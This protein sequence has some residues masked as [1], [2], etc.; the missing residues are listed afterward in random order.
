M[1]RYELVSGNSSKFWQIDLDDAAFTTS[2]G[3][4]GTSGQTKTKTFANASAA[5][6]AHDK[7]VAEK[8]KKGYVLVVDTTSAPAPSAPHEPPAAAPAAAPAPAE[9][10]PARAVE[11]ADE[12]LARAVEPADEALA[13]AVEP[14]LALDPA[15]RS[16][17]DPAAYPYGRL[18]WTPAL[19]KLAAESVAAVAPITP[20][21]GEPAVLYAQ[22]NRWTR[23]AAKA[24]IENG[25]HYHPQQPAFV[26]QV[27]WAYFAAAPP[28]SLDVEVESAAFLMLTSVPGT[29]QRDIAWTMI[30]Y[31]VAKAGLAFAVEAWART[32]S[33]WT[34]MGYSWKTQ[35]KLV[36]LPADA[37]PLPGA[38]GAAPPTSE[39]INRHDVVPLLRRLLADADDPAG[40]R[41]HVDTLLGGADHVTRL[42]LAVL[43]VDVASIC[44]ALTARGAL[45]REMF[46]IGWDALSLVDPEVLPELFASMGRTACVHLGSVAGS[47]YRRETDLGPLVRLFDRHREAALPA[48]FAWARR[49]VDLI[50]EVGGPYHDAEVLDLLKGLLGLFANVSDSRPL[51]EMLAE[52]Q[53]RFAKLK[54]NKDEDPR[55]AALQL[56]NAM[57][58]LALGAV[59]AHRQQGWAKRVLPQLERATGAVA[60][61]PVASDDRIPSELRGQPFTGAPSFWD[62]ELLPQLLLDEHSALPPASVNTIGLALSRDDTV[63]ID[64]AKASCTARSLARF[65]WGLFSAWEA[66]GAPSK[67]KWAMMALGHFGDDEVAQNLTPLIRRWPGESQHSRAVNGLEVLSA[68]GSDV[69]MMCLNG[70]AQKVKFKALQRNAR[71]KMAAIAAR[72][73]FTTEELEDRLVPDLDLEDDGTM[74]LDFGPRSFR[75]G[76]DE[77]LKPYVVDAKGKRRASLPSPGAKDDAALATEAVERFK[78]MKQSVRSL[79]ALQVARLEQAMGRRRWPAADF[80]AFLVHHPLMFH[81]VRR[82]VWGVLDAEHRPTRC[83]RVAEDRSYA[84]CDD[85]PFELPSDA[86]VG[87]VHRLHLTDTE[88]TS[89]RTVFADYELL[90]PFDQLD[91]EIFRL[92]PTDVAD[93]GITRFMNREVETGKLRGLMSRG[94]RHG[95]PQDAGFYHAFGKPIRDDLFAWLPIANGI[96]VSGGGYDDDTQKL[97]AIIFATDEPGYWGSPQLVPVGAIDEITL[98]ELLRDVEALGEV[99][100]EPA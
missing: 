34:A 53:T 73:G 70:I 32:L 31:W 94:W 58:A 29:P 64:A 87:L 10:A 26:K 50:A 89:W 43:V 57:P 86:T 83:F 97:G 60:L 35:P 18:T 6:S 46:I 99:P 65:A 14:D 22:I 93:G 63:V 11:P 56:L 66:A 33:P 76:F 37:P 59:R 8:V 28:E 77:A 41:A 51:A 67:Q 39:R 12:A 15:S 48:A 100:R 88:R 13:R 91:R 92:E 45:N 95:T 78:T 23:G 36:L 52:L 25:L 84:D 27:P 3:R 38:V 7:L 81:L 40:L 20:S 74:E 98:S 90:A 9:E 96:S 4:I 24:A 30:R 19:A 1:A 68:I 82:L 16:A 85:A 79:A 17:P 75:V 62:P 44:E 71:D 61:A 5:K 21:L 54:F 47:H 55:P 49:C 2:F 72:R 80:E 42:G 69:A